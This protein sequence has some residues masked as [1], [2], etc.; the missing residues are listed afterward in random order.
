[1]GRLGTL[2]RLGLGKDHADLNTREK[3]NKTQVRHLRVVAGGGERTKGGSEKHDMTH[4]GMKQEIT[5]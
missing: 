2:G 3:V 1:M 4:D 5:N